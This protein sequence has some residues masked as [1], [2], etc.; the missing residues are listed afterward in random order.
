[1]NLMAAGGIEH[2]RR[3][4]VYLI[5]LLLSQQGLCYCY[6]FYSSSRVYPLPGLSVHLVYVYY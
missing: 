6:Q 2:S 4:F 5:R 3:L 1:M